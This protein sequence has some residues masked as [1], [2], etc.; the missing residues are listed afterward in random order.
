MREKGKWRRQRRDSR[1]LEEE[2]YEELERDRFKR[3]HVVKVHA[4]Y[5]PEWLCMR[6]RWNRV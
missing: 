3:V 1:K 2:I 6:L 5:L 4:R